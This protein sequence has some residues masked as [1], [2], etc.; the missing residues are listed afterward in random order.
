TKALLALM[1]DRIAQDDHDRDEP[2]DQRHHAEHKEKHEKRLRR[3]LCRLSIEACPCQQRQR[4]AHTHRLE[5]LTHQSNESE[6]ESSP[7]LSALYCVKVNHVSK[8]GRRE[9]G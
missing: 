6:D 4:D 3:V 1:S 9:N 7:R 5:R 2:E 8:D